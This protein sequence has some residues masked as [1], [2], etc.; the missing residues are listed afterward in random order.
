MLEFK[1][2]ILSIVQGLGFSDFAFMRL[3]CGDI[4]SRLLLTTPADM[5]ASYFGGGFM[6][7]DMM[8]PYA[9]HNFVLFTVRDALATSKL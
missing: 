4:D 2:K 9:E 6:K 3:H 5:L 7:Y 1:D 8:V